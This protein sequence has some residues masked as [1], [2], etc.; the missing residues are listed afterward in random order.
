MFLPTLSGPLSIGQNQFAYTKKR[1][2]CDAIAYLV[3]S[4]LAAFK[5]KASV[6]LY[7]SD[8]SGAFD[9]V[10]AQRLL[11]KLRARGMPEDVL[12]CH[13]F[14]ASQ[15]AKFHRGWQGIGGDVP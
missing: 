6:A 5:E 4:W 3:L 11:E 9:R 7:M 10:S 13:Q 8:V 14:V 15:A 1:G 12:G 2:A